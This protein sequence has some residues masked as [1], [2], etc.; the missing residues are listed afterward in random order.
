M[1]S[2]LV[3]L[4][5]SNFHTMVNISFQYRSKQ[6]KSQLEIRISYSRKKK[7]I[8][9]YAK[10]Q[11]VVEREFFIEY[12]AGKQ[13]KDITK[14]NKQ[15]DLSDQL[16]ALKKFIEAALPHETE[17]DSDTLKQ[18]VKDFYFPTEQHE[19]PDHFL[20]Y[21]D[22]YLSLRELDF[23]VKIRTWQKWQA[24]KNK[25]VRFF[26]DTGDSLKVEE[27]NEAFKNLWIE[28][29]TKQQ[30]AQSTIMKEL[31]MIKIVCT[32][33]QS[34][35]VKVS[36]DIVSR[37]KMKGKNI[38]L[39]IIYLTMTELKGIMQ[40]DDLPEYLENARD[41]LLISCF[42]GQRVSDFMRFDASMLNVV[43]GKTFLDVQQ[44]KTGRA[45]SIP[46]TDQ[47]LNIL[48]KR[49]GKFPRS[50]SDQKYNDYVK[51]VCRLA[52]INNP[53][54]GRLAKVVQ[55]DGKN[56][57][58][59]IVGTY[60]KWQLIG[61]HIGRRSFASNYYQRLKTSEIKD[62]TGHSTEQMLLQYIGKSTDS[63]KSKTHD[64][65]NNINNELL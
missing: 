55:I 10:T 57:T 13:F 21:L 34:K 29:N 8:S 15:T 20:A 4:I 1:C 28:W 25:I 27:I 18:I 31:K 64:D 50:I 7:R 45:V 47:V 24:V 58:R 53:T 52:G 30:Y 26:A 49:D 40:L 14:K 36:P 23:K 41:W 32:H 6:E 44:V 61:S 33:A 43:D 35:G 16:S 5:C 11:I 46:I 17:I 63:K 65:M 19:T 38:E 22:Y 37:L 42:T 12:Q 51:E 3:S 56:E 9:R 39:P 60:E 62:I 54:K 59:K 48:N 2:I